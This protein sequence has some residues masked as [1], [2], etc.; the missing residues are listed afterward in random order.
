MVGGGVG[1][2]FLLELVSVVPS[3]DVD[4]GHNV[5][6]NKVDNGDLASL[7]H[8]FSQLQGFDCC[9]IGYFVL[10][11]ENHHFDPLIESRPG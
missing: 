4:V 11:Q 1:D 2:F 3:R 6:F 5:D 8:E 7:K 10:V 9:C